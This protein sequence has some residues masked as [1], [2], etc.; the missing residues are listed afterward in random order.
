MQHVPCKVF[1]LSS[2]PTQIVCAFVNPTSCPFADFDIQN[3]H[4]R[5][6]LCTAV[7]I[8]LTGCVSSNAMSVMGWC[9]YVCHDILIY[10]NSS[11]IMMQEASI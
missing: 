1:S 2:V 4:H 11:I 7:Q 5:L 8:V 3:G 9:T 10:R 6:M